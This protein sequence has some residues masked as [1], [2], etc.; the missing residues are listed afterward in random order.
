M[1]D[2]YYFNLIAGN[3]IFIVCMPIS[4][5]MRC[6]YTMD[7]GRKAEWKMLN[8]LML[9]WDHI[10]SIIVLWMKL[11]LLFVFIFILE[12]IHKFKYW[13]KST[14]ICHSFIK[15]FV[16]FVVWSLIADSCHI[17]SISI[18]RELIYWIIII[19]IHIHVLWMHIMLRDDRGHGKAKN[20]MLC[21][22]LSWN[23]WK[24][25]QY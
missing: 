21:V 5:D 6:L 3:I 20:N 22:C 2:E 8:C 7:E 16:Q 4:M 14:W 25:N 10:S 12:R 17:M 1:N 15:S 13:Y 19:M 11:Y 23:A 9:F 24:C 18:C